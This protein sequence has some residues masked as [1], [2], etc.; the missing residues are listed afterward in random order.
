MNR[1]EKFINYLEGL[2]TDKNAKLLESISN[3]F[4]TLVEYRIGGTPAEKVV[5]IMESEEDMIDEDMADEI[6]S[7]DPV[8]LVMESE[9]EIDEGVSEETNAMDPVLE[10]IMD[11]NDNDNLN[12]EIL[13]TIDNEV[14]HKIQTMSQM[15]DSQ[16]LVSSEEQKIKYL[17]HMRGQLWRDKLIERGINP[18]KAKGLI[19]AMAESI[20]EADRALLESVNTMLGRS[21]LVIMESTGLDFR[22]LNHRGSTYSTLVHDSKQ[23]ARTILEYP[24]DTIDVE[25]ANKLINLANR[26]DKL[27]EITKRDEEPNDQYSYFVDTFNEYSKELSRLAYTANIPI[28][29]STHKS[30]GM[31][32]ENYDNVT[33]AKAATV[34][35]KA[36]IREIKKY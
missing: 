15:I 7:E 18:S 30:T 9:E 1:E 26:F 11:N 32:L 21:K 12:S 8:D 16:K 27:D 34:S 24:L 10:D 19:P 3:G 33:D 14:E 2:K 31:L 36:A 4:K 23:V 20:E 35:K 13:R 28:L 25:L 17:D 5:D 6:A 22:F 29:E